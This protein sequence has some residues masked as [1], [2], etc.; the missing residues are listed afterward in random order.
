MR[1]MECAQV[2]RASETASSAPGPSTA[3]KLSQVIK[4]SL[5]PREAFVTLELH[6]T[7]IVRRAHTRTARASAAEMHACVPSHT[8][9]SQSHNLATTTALTRVPSFTSSVMQ[10]GCTPAE[11]GRKA[12]IRRGGESRVFALLVGWVERTGREMSGSVG[13]CAARRRRKEA[14]GKV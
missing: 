6:Y 1:E 9:G 14:D 13:W 7:H 3:Q 12:G 4:K 8:R 11:P 2:R 10:H 5:L